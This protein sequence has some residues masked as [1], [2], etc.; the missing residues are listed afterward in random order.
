MP[1]SRTLIKYNSETEKQRCSLKAFVL[2]YVIETTA[3][4]IAVIKGIEIDQPP[5]L[6]IE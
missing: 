4:Q 2:Y 3:Y 5:T 1:S 6:G